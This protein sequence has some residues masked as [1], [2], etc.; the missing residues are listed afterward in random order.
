MASGDCHAS[1]CDCVSSVSI[2]AGAPT[3]MVRICA[4]CGLYYDDS[5]LPHK[6]PPKEK[7]AKCH[8]DIDGVVRLVE[9]QPYHHKCWYG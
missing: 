9:G 4:N 2:L 7:C 6:C 8:I 1:W 3:L 5:V